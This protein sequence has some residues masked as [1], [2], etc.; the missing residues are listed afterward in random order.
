VLALLPRPAVPCP[1]GAPT[2]FFLA[3][4]LRRKSCSFISLLDFHQMRYPGN[5][6]ARH[7]TI[8]MLHRLIMR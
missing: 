6:A 2:R 1:R 5:H 4:A 8:G 7:W 3:R